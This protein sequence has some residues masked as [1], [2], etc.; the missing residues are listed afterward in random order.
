MLT[1]INK[2]IAD[3]GIASRR[4]A[5]EYIQQGRVTVNDKVIDKLSFRIDPDKD[6]VK[7]DGE[8]I[9]A[10]RHVYYL[11]NKPKGFISST[12]DEKGRATVIDL[13]KT[14]EKV[15]PVGR[16]DYNTTGVLLLTNDGDFS[17][18]LMHPKSKVPRIYHAKLNRELEEKDKLKLLKGVFIDGK[19]GK[20][21][22]IKFPKHN[23]KK[24]V[25]VECYEG[26]NHFVKNMF[27]ALG[28]TVKNLNRY[29]FAGIKADIQVGE[30]RK[31]TEAE[32]KNIIKMYSKNIRRN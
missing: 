19:R 15:F 9:R 27:S 13:I 22:N 7:V 3:S 6:V 32:V 29:S 5:E 2:F 24:L 30:Y 31:L 12:K 17:N 21:I 11:L 18:L 28:Y 4:K 20:F 10:K 8:I 1:R 23:D 14:K 26:R 25:E 16:L